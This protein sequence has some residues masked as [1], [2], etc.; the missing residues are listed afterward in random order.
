MTD[1]GLS[2][3]YKIEPTDLPPIPPPPVPEELI[4][5]CCGG[6]PCINDVC[7]EERAIE[8]PLTVQDIEGETPKPKRSNRTNKQ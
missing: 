1:K 4:V 7:T 2:K 5:R 3:L 6:Q 8:E